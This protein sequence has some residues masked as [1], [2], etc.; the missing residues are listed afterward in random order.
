[1]PE[2]SIDITAHR[3]L[4]PVFQGDGDFAAW[5]PAPVRKKFK[6]L[7]AEAQQA[8]NEARA[9]SDKRTA[10]LAAVDD[11]QG[12]LAALTLPT[13]TRSPNG[14][15]GHGLTENSAQVT[16]ARVQ[17]VSMREDLADLNERY[18]RR[19]GGSLSALVQRIEEFLGRRGRAPLQI[20]HIDAPVLKKGISVPEAIEARRRRLR[21]L[22]ADL[23]AVEQTP[24]PSNVTKQMAR[25]QME[26]LAKRGRPDVFGLVE[27]C[28]P[29]EWPMLPA[30]PATIELPQMI[31]VDALA[32]V[33]WA[34]GPA[35][36]A[37]VE[38]EIDEISDDA[39]AL[40]AEQ[41]M[42]RRQQINGDMLAVEREEEALVELAEAE[43]ITVRRRSDADPRAVLGLSG[44]LRA[45]DKERIG[46]E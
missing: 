1:M 46:V 11:E 4:M 24:W 39:A 45:P 41:R 15:I 5:L 14:N 22:A 44:D 3:N 28:Q 29:I 32:L 19:D 6:R 43:G 17:L 2:Q 25:A 40:V 34:L 7:R 18:G 21:E 30:T 13:N 10:L 20:V 23:R 36:V 26:E 37:A 9:L 31:R 12:K 35:L 42:E 16:A 33:A 38:R 27:R 8:R